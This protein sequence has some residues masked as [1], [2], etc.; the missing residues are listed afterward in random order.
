MALPPQTMRGGPLLCLPRGGHRDA[1][2]TRQALRSP[3]LQTTAASQR[4]DS[5]CPGHRAGG[6]GSGRGPPCPGPHA[7]PHRAVG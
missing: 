1:P 3:M 4:G 6:S 2:T 5:I 7:P